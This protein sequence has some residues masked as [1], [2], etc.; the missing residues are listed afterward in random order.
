VEPPKNV[1]ENLYYREWLKDEANK[2]KL[3][4]RAIWQ[5]CAQNVLFY[6]NTF[7]WTFDP[8]RSHLYEPPS[9]TVPFVT[10]PYQDEALLVMGDQIDKGEDLV[11]EKSRDMGASWLS[12]VLMEHRWHFHRGNTFLMISRKEHLVDKPG[13]PDALFWKIDFLHQ[14]LPK[15]LLPKM[16]RTKL[17][18]GNLDLN[19]TIDGDSTTDASGVGGRRT[20]VF[21][22]EFSRMDNAE[23][24]LGGLAD[25]TDCRIIN[26]T[27]WGTNNAAHKVAKD[28]GKKKLRFHWSQHPKKS[29]G[30]YKYDREKLHVEFL[31]KQNPPDAN[32]PFIRDGKLRSPWYDKECVRRGNN[33]QQIAQHLDI[34]YE[35]SGFQFF[36]V[37]LLDRLEEAYCVAPLE[38]GDVY[39]D[40]VGHLR[41]FQT[42]GG[43]PLRLWLRLDSRQRPARSRYVI[44]CDASS[45]TGASNTCFSIVDLRTGEKV[46]EYANPKIQPVDAALKLVALSRMFCNEEDEPAFLIWEVP[47]PGIALGNKIIELGV[48]N[49]YWRTDE[50]ST[51]KKQSA[52]PGWHALPQNQRQL[53]EHYREMLADGRFV[54]RSKEALR[55]CLAFV[56]TPQGTV[57][58][59]ASLA[60]DDPS[61]ARQN[62]GDRVI[63]DA[64]AAK[65]LFERGV[66]LKMPHQEPEIK[67]GSMAWRRQQAEE[68]RKKAER[69]L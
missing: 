20:A 5:E 45:G 41:E 26:F 44:G 22:D 42:Q 51:L 37:E 28:P 14:Y 39:A 52:R 59:R 63:A 9:K 2:S 4:Q 55:E 60:L 18:F 3:L 23:D 36:D 27:P 34:D 7:V 56:F 29:K 54:N 8:R 50:F 61:G 13:N 21:L 10:W 12:L 38:Q 67:P 66:T 19:S 46:G 57:A 40:D 53:M 47:G 30:A 31:D 33:K 15:W 49:V 62:H 48:R 58:H 25:V 11:I 64:L 68:E 32:Y 16:E 69:W 6:V 24:V 1:R 65:I 35:G 43:G 17:H